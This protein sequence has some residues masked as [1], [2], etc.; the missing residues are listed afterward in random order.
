MIVRPQ[1]GGPGFREID[2][3]VRAL[4][5]RPDVVYFNAHADPSSVPPRAIVYNFENIGIQ[6][7]PHDHFTGNVIWDFSRRNVERWHNAGREATHV[8]VGYHPSMALFRPKPW[9]ERA[10]DV[11]LVGCPNERRQ[12]LLDRLER[13][14]LR[15]RMIY[16]LFGAERDAVLADTRVVLNPLYYEQGVFPVLRQIHAVA[17]GLPV[18]SEV[19]PEAPGWTH[20]GPVPYEAMADHAFEL[21]RAPAGNVDN[22]VGYATKVLHQHPLSL[23]MGNLRATART[24]R[25]R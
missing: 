11:T 9:S 14:G 23:P 3:A 24:A 15:V 22:L 4:V 6:L 20:P 21:A 5:G 19:A 18:V 17:N 13:R 1:I 7:E 16:G 25:Q 10:L 8:P 12:A 2:T